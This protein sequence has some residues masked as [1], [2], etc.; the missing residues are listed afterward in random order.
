MHLDQRFIHLCRV[1]N[2]QTLGGI[3]L[4]EYNHLNNKRS[5]KPYLSLISEILQDGLQFLM[6]TQQLLHICSFKVV[7]CSLGFFNSF[8][9]SL[10]VTL[11][12]LEIC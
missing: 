10:N 9:I 11:Y 12:F 2:V 7:Q 6:E 5:L 4:Q 3:R 8:M 1:Y